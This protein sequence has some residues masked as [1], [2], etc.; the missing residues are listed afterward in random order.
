METF[1]DT[2]VLYNKIFKLYKKAF[3]FNKSGFMNNFEK[4]LTYIF[5]L[6]RPNITA[7]YAQYGL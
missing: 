6:T 2:N 4:L 7:I 1:N 3:N 5:Y